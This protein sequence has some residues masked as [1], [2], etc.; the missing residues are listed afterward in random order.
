MLKLRTLATPK[1]RERIWLGLSAGNLKRLPNDEP[2]WV[3]GEEL[4]ID[5]DIIIF[6]GE[7]EESMADDLRAQGLAIPRTN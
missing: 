1:T 7:T 4:G 2:I 5:F 6:A 3:H